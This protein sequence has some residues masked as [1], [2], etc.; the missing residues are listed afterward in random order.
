MT[1]SSL[2]RKLAKLLQDLAGTF[3]RSLEIDYDG[4][5]CASFFAKVGGIYRWQVILRGPDPVRL[6]QEQPAGGWL[7]DWRLE[8]DPISLL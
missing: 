3:L 6:L 4:G 2:S 8:V 5:S 7:K 1:Q